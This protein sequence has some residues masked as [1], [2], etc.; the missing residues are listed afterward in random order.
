MSTTR[1]RALSVRAGVEL[2]T[3]R[4]MSGDA[5]VMRLPAAMQLNDV[6][7]I[8]EKLS[9]DPNV[10]YAEPDAK[11]FAFAQPN[12][13]HFANGNQ[14]HFD[15]PLGGINLPAAWDVT[16]GNASVT[17][18]VVDSGILPHADLAGRTVSG[19]D[20]ISNATKANDGSGRDSDPTDPG[21]WVTGAETT[22]ASGPFFGCDVTWSTWHGTFVAGIIGAASNNAMGVAGVNWNSKILPVRVLGK[23]GGYLSDIADGIRWAAGLSVP[24][25]PANANPA[26]VINLSLGSIDACSPSEQSAISAAL[27]QGAVVVTAAGNENVDASLS[28][29]GN[30]TGVINVAA[31]DHDGSRASYSNKGGGVTVSAPGGDIGNIYSTTNLGA[32]S[33]TTDDYQGF[34]EVGTSFAAPHVSGVAS[35]MFSVNPSLT[36]TQVKTIIRDT[37]RAFPTTSTYGPQ[38]VCDTATCGA[39]IVDAA[40]AVRRAQESWAGTNTSA[41]LTFADTQVGQTSAALDVQFTNGTTGTVVLGAA[42]RTGADAAGFTIQSD[43]CSNATIPQNG[44]CTVRVAFMPTR[45]GT[46][47]AVLEI[48]SPAFGKNAVAQLAGNGIAAPVS[49]PPSTGGST[50]VSGTPGT[51][52]TTDSTGTSGLVSTTTNTSSSGGGGGGGGCAMSG[53][54][55]FDPVLPALFA[56]SLFFLRRRAAKVNN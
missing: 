46:H 4:A 28:A 40:A 45:A 27:A 24:G 8:A 54:G 42:L 17:V 29:P 37:V 26:K 6:K 11:R 33:P 14:W 56:G 51:S 48:P 32:M 2:K 36:P 9:A 23:C 7:A 49:T 25:V 16:T 39:G 52:G 3:H 22:A 34:G 21:D 38:Y 41:T 15:D 18:A 31:T 35:L 50:G 53:K 20:F 55:G 10:M 1:A 44:N 30:C 43:T 5:H 13:P 19:Y 12:D 47:S